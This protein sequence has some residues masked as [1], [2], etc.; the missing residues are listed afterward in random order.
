MTIQEKLT[1]TKVK[2]I[3]FKQVPEFSKVHDSVVLGL[4][5]RVGYFQKHLEKIRY[6]INQGLVELIIFDCSHGF[7]TSLKAQY[8][9]YQVQFSRF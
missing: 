9:W 8:R 3:L 4:L 6:L 5:R 2:S 7:G 1:I